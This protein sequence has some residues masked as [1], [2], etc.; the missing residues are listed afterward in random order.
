M[1]RLQEREPAFK[2]EIT[3]FLTLL[4]VLMMSLVGALVESASMQ[5]A[6]NHKR[7]NTVLALESTFAEYD[8]Q[9]LKRYDLF[10]REECTDSVLQ[11][12][13]EYYGAD[14]MNHTICKQ[15][16]LSDYK[17]S[18]FY[19]QAVRYGKDW[20]GIDKAPEAPEYELYSETYLEE[21]E[22]VYMDLEELLAQEQGELP[23]EN[24]PLSTVQRLKDTDLITL[25]YPSPEN[26]SNRHIIIEDLPSARQLHA[27][28]W[29]SYEKSQNVD[30]MFLVTYLREH[31]G[32]FAEEKDATTLA[33]EQ[34]YLIGGYPSDKEN[35]EKVCEQLLSVRM[36]VNYMY[37][38]TDTAKQAEAEALSL[39]LCSLLTVPGVTEVVKHALLLAWAY[40]ESVIDVRVLLKGKQV[41]AVKSADTWQL[42]LANLVKLGTDEE[43]VNEVDVAGGISYQGYL[44]GL[45]YMRQK[46][47]LS[48][49]SLDLIESN[50]RIKT[51]QCTT[52]V[53]IT[54][55]VAL[56]RGVKDSFSTTFAYQ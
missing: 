14:H 20:L 17:G 36:V 19:E 4:F 7:A 43:I 44:T 34:E 24:N 12:R 22:L 29:G 48:M 51:D 56:R 23:E 54:S 49:R 15:E 9:M 2:G 28:N 10:V 39:T 33:Y 45:I 47:T 1:K 18:P 5:M 21:E 52:K 40:G 26:I 42:Q 41:P 50:L 3:A 27:G 13:L 6:K 35:L 37:L 16:Y 32:S 53:Q 55:N 11:D 30:K 31:F 25:V 46:E 8:R 38:L